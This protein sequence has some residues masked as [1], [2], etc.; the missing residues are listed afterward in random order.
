MIWPRTSMGSGCPD[1]MSGRSR[2]WAASRA[3]NSTPEIRTRSPAV[4]ASTSSSVR[5]GLTRLMPSAPTEIT[6]GSRE[7]RVARPT[8]L[9]RS[10]HR[11]LVPVSVTLDGDRDGK[12]GDVARVGQD[13]NP[14]G[15]RVPAIALRADA[16][17]VRAVQHLPLERVHHRVGVRGAQLPEQRLLRQAGR[18]LEGAADP[19]PGDQRWTGVWSRGLDAFEDPLLDALHAFRGRQ[20]LVL[21]PVLAASTL[22]HDLDLEGGARDQVEMDHGRRVVAGVHTIERRARDGGAQVALRVALPHALVDGVGEETALHVHVLAQLDKAHDEA[23]VLAVRDLL[24]H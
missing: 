22:G 16:E 24:G 23:R 5:G 1:S 18:L 11:L 12:R 8:R 17:P 3:V 7:A 9:A 20:H 2:A 19:D 4:S 10:Q 15:G 13:V 14:E 21:G 6:A